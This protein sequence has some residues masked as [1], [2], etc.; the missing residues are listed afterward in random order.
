M[1]SRP[2]TALS[3][4]PRRPRGRPTADN[5]AELENRLIAV[6]REA[7][8]RDG[9]GAT[10][11]DKVA[12]AARVSKSTLYGRFPTKEALFRGIIQAQ[13]GAWEAGSN[14]RLLGV[15]DTLEDTLMMYGETWLRAGMSDDYV[16]M[17][18]LMFSES[19]R[20]PELAESARTS[21]KRG[22]EAIAKMLE[23]FAQKD[24]VPCRNP[25]RAAEIFQ[26]MT[27]GWVSHA[28]VAATPFK[29]ATARAWL[30]DAVALFIA[31]RATW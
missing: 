17:S 4:Q 24:G 15:R 16:Q 6:A 1:P 29:Q 21:A 12:A 22:V 7:F 18:R 19:G 11:M 20:F 14:L 28:I 30:Q 27:T 3:E 8:F 26:S 25:E 23:H 13:I 31:G 2:T 10:T 9:Y 5:L